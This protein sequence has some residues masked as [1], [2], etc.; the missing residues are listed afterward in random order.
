MRHGSLFSGIGGFDLAAEWMGWENIFQVEIDLFCQKVLKKNFPNVKKY[1]DVRAFDGTKY[2]G[3]IDILSGGF[4]C[5]PFSYAGKRKGK[6]DVRFI[7]SEMLRVIREIKPAFVVAENVNGIIGMVLNQML[8]EME[9]EGYITETFII[10]ACA[11]NAPHRRDRVWMVAYSNGNDVKHDTSK[12]QST[13][14][15]TEGKAQG[16]HRERLRSEFGAVCEN[17]P[18]TNSARLQ[19]LREQGRLPQTEGQTC[20]GAERGNLLGRK[21]SAT[22]WNAEPAVGRVANGVSNRVDRIKSLG[23]SIV[24]QVAFEI[25][26]AIEKIN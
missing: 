18:D 1:G 3:A 4:P 15:Q 20:S 21:W 7:W 25:F 13:A 16:T 24:P 10:P 17:V 26:K 6:D 11:I 12:I 22:W 9:A 8:A 23:N 19:T 14:N 5:Q 2:R